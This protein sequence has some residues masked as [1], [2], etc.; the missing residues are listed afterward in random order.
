MLSSNL[1]NTSHW[2][3]NDNVTQNSF[4]QVLARM[5][6]ARCFGLRLSSSDG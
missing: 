6:S 1:P 5:A 2:R 4:M 3:R